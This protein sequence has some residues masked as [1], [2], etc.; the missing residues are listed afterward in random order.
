MYNGDIMARFNLY[1]N[2]LLS[3]IL[4]TISIS[5]IAQNFPAPSV[6]VVPAKI[7]SL[8]PVSW[9]SGTVVSKNDAK[10]AAEISGRLIYLVEIGSQVNAG[11]L[12]A[13]LDDKALQIQL[14]E[15]QAKVKKAQAQL[16][17]LQSELKRK[18]TLVKQN[19]SAITDLDKTRSER[20]IAQGDLAIAKSQLALTKQKLTYSQLKAPFTGIVV[21]RLGSLGEY[22]NNGTAI[23]RLVQ[24]SQREASVFIP[25]TSYQYM[26]KYLNSKAG[27][28]IKSA[29]G[30]KIVPLIAL[31]PVADKRSHLIE[32]RLSLTKL[33]WPIGLNIKVAIANS[34]NK[35]V[36]AVPRDAL[37]L[38]RNGISLFKV[39]KD[40]K[41]EQVSVNVGIGAGEWVEVIGNV[42]PND[43]IIVRGNERVRAGQVVQVKNNNKNLISSKNISLNN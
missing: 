26:K 21:Q 6:N 33:D 24:T 20:D 18:K 10:I 7:T 16:N 22:V 38:R 30:N 2:I 15:D 14:K 13:K 23:I 25:V 35:K 29:L 1:K 42:S 12:L 17:F 11:D 3:I 40:N 43:K 19:L 37:V 5:A 34:N 4:L 31:I 9:M 36:L 28:A 39:N 32:A 8:A 27:V 41:A